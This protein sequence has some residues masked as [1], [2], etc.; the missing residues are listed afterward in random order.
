MGQNTEEL[1]TTPA[2]IEA[3]R[4]DL[5]RNIDELSDKVSPQRVVERRKQAARNSLSS[6]RDKLMGSAQDVR[7]SGS[8]RKSRECS[9]ASL[10]QKNRV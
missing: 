1:S 10:S 4:A 9:S 5:S 6:V 3:T 8:G 2:D 7:S